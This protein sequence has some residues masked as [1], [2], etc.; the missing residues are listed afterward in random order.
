MADV[1]FSA[2]YGWGDA[3]GSKVLATQTFEFDLQ[4][5]C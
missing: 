5:P 1:D 3:S 2:N 4:K